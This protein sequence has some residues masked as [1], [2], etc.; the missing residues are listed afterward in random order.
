MEFRLLGPL[1]VRD[2]GRLLALGGAKQRGLLAILLLHANQVVSSDQL[3]GAL[4]GEEP[5]QS[6]ASALRVHVAQ[7]RKAL[8]G[9]QAVLVTRAPG[10]LVEVESD[11]LD[12]DRFERLT[13]EAGRALADGRW[14][15]ASSALREALA[16]WRGPPLA[17]FADAPFA[18]AQIGRLQE[19]RLV[20]LER[21]IH[22]ELALGEHADLVGELQ[23]LVTEQPLREHLRAQLM[24]AL[25]RCGRQAEALATYQETRRL[26]L[27][28]L[29]IEPSAE[30]QQLERAILRQE[31][32][33][34]LQLESAS[35]MTD[36]PP[37]NLPAQSMPLVGRERELAATQSVLRRPEVRLV[38]LTGPGGTGKTRLALE[39]AREF[40][41]EWVDGVFL[42]TLA[43]V[44]DPRL[45]ASA[46]AGTLGIK[47]V[48]GLPLGETLK[49]ALRDKRLLL[50]LDNFE[51]L[52]EAAPLVAELLAAAPG[53]K[54]LVTS[55]AAV[56]LSAEHEFPVPPLRLPDAKRAADLHALASTEAVE[57]FV[58]RAQAVRPD[59]LLNQATASAVAEICVRL[60]GLPLAIELA[61]ARIKLLSP[62]AMLVRLEQ[63]LRL[64]TGGPRDLPARQRT[65]RATIDW[66]YD[67]LA[68]EEQLVFGRLAVFAGGFTL[69]GAEAVANPPGELAV[70]L[71]DG[72]SSLVDQSVLQQAEGAD[73]EPR[74]WMLETIREYALERLGDS[75]EKAAV[76]NAHAS[77][78]LALAEAAEPQLRGSRQAQWL[79]RLDT[80]HDNV[81]AALAWT[82]Q[83]GTVE[84]GLRLGAALWRFWQIRGYLAE[85]REFLQRLLELAEPPRSTAAWANAWACVGRLAWAQ[86]DF[87]V[88]REL[89]EQSLWVHRQLGDQPG[90]AF[91]L[92]NLGMVAHEQGDY[93]AAVSLL[94]EGAAGFRRAGDAWGESMSLRYLGV[95]VQALGDHA[96]ARSSLEECLRLARQ[97]GD[98]RI[99]AGGLVAIG[100]LAREQGDLVLARSRFA[101]ALAINRD[102]GDA[103]G[104]PTALANLGAVA[105]AQGDTGAA[106]AYLE[107]AFAIRG[108][109]GDQAGMAAS[110]EH[111]ASLTAMEGRPAQAVRIYGAAAALRETIGA[112]PAP[113]ERAEVQQR[114][115]GLRVALG[116]ERT[117]QAWAQGQAMPLEETVAHA[118]DRADATVSLD[119][120]AIT[121]R[122]R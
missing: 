75:G 55:R 61:A 50:V 53:V 108:A 107:E 66:S 112:R 99:I 12:L 33:L 26:L 58:Q 11:Q 103:W 38:T 79:Q 6:A 84:A 28:E 86:G 122:A 78:F 4:W 89:F 115:G 68:P 7:L 21:R 85:G 92:T 51:H 16:L 5:P 57:L 77:F 10:Y 64:L 82:A 34:D 30:L 119:G 70:N 104:I 49:H 8:G 101:E 106:R 29:G 73:G 98:L 81:R 52:V 32:S 83:G 56:H 120:L 54:V 46:I 25:Y 91:S 69:Q 67:L 59:F 42:V 40:L 87:Q 105:L 117:A 113:V 41:G 15:E 97:V 72:L 47:E 111:L 96:L 102:L 74:F 13:G 71:L 90:V 36:H 9:G 3:T 22:A 27:E 23:T 43:P 24:L 48:G 88:A 1:E 94:G 76:R 14:R 44:R 63:R 20:A 118:L 114:L 17:D 116:Q 65:L 45:V 62:Q 100:L 31:P 2:E 19:L 35:P 39:L 80:E 109:A 37:N 110:L 60:D 18:Q 95:S 93:G 121:E